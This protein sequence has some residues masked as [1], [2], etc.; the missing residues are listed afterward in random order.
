M[1]LIENHRAHRVV[2]YILGVMEALLGLRL[3]FKLLGAN[4]L[5][6]FVSFLYSLTGIFILPF[7]GIFRTVSSAQS[8]FEPAAVVAMVIYALI[9]YGILKLFKL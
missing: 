4:P 6:A 1:E 5:N 9:A 3:L 8:I 7:L 2:Y